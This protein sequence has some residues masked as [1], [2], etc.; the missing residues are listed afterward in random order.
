MFQTLFRKRNVWRVV[1][2]LFFLGFF[3]CAIRVEAASLNLIPSA[4]KVSVGNIVSVGVYVDTGGRAINNAEA[5]IEF[6]TDVLEVISVSKKPSIFTLWVEEPSFSN[7]TGTVS[8]NGGV[9]NPGFTGENGSIASITFRAKKAGSASLLFSSSAVR[10]NDGLGTDILSVKNGSSITVAGIGEST[11]PSAQEFGGATTPA[12]VITSET[13]PDQDV[14]YALDTATFNWKIQKGVTSIQTLFDTNARALPTITYDSSVTQKTLSSISDGVFYFH[15]RYLNTSGWGPI[16]HYKVRVDT[17]A[18][19]PFTPTVRLEGDVVYMTLNAVDTVS[20]IQKYD[21]RF[22]NAEGLSV[23]KTVLKSALVNNE[24]ALPALNQGN[25]TAVVTAYDK[26]GNHTEATVSF[27]S[28]VVSVPKISLSTREINT[29]ESVVVT[30]TSEYIG[31]QVEVTL[32]SNGKTIA[33]S[34]QTIASDGSFSV[35]T[36]KIKTAGVVTIFA[37]NIL[38]STVRSQPSTKLFLTVNETMVIK[39]ATLIFWLI[40]IALLISVLLIVAYV[41]WHRFLGIRKKMDQ[42]LQR[43]A[44]STHKAMNSLKDE[45]DKQ[46][47]DLERTKVDRALNEKEERIFKDLQD[48]VDSIDE[49]IEKDLQKML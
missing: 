2:I 23:E 17:T 6:P 41:G 36:Q 9:A 18:P 47:K 14:W 45:L 37:E 13:H 35:T 22:D 12:P 42:E 10:Q 11:P 25:Y 19:R 39:V 28:P 32:E 38:S 43:T 4:T 46:L 44:K 7:Y 31:K 24:Y 5:T 40:V 48:S 15:L 20:G 21:I 27:V 3:S 29:G 33:T 34:T 26:A 8:F 16:A 30:G 1:P 49:F